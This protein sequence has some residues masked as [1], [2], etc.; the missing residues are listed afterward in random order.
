M[1][2]SSTDISVSPIQ[3]LDFASFLQSPE[4]IEAI[5]K[6]YTP[7]PT[8]VVLTNA[9][10]RTL[11]QNA[12]RLQTPAYVIPDHLFASIK[13]QELWKDSIIQSHARGMPPIKG[14]IPM[15]A[16]QSWITPA[17]VVSSTSTALDW[18][19]TAMQDWFTTYPASQRSTHI[20]ENY[21]QSIRT[22][23]ASQTPP[24]FL[25]TML[26]EPMLFQEW[27][28]AIRKYY[29]R[30][31]LQPLEVILGDHVLVLFSLISVIKYPSLDIPLPSFDLQWGCILMDQNIKMTNDIPKL[32]TKFESLT[33]PTS[34]YINMKHF[35]LFTTSS[36]QLAIKWDIFLKDVPTKIWRAAI[37]KCLCTKRA[38]DWID[39]EM[40]SKSFPSV[41]A[42]I[43][44]LI[45]NRE[46]F[47]AME[48]DPAPPRPAHSLSLP[49]Q[50]GKKA[51]VAQVKSP[52]LYSDPSMEEGGCFNPGCPL[53]N[54]RVRQCNNPCKLPDCPNPSK[55]HMAR[56]C[57]LL[58][59]ES[60]GAYFAK[61]T[62]RTA[63]CSKC[64]PPKITFSPSVLRNLQPLGPLRPPSR[65]NVL[66]ASFFPLTDSSII[67]V[68]AAPIIRFDTG[69]N[70][71]VSP[72][73]LNSS[74]VTPMCD[75]LLTAQ[76]SSVDII[77]SSP[78]GSSV[79]YIAPSLTDALISQEFIEK[80][81]CISVLVDNKLLLFDINNVNNNTLLTTIHSSLPL[82]TI[83]AINGEYLLSP[84]ILNSLVC[85]PS[86]SSET[87]LYAAKQVRKCNVV[88]AVASH[89]ANIA[90]YYTVTF[91]S[92]RDVVLYWHFA[93]GHA[94]EEKMVNIVEHQLV[95]NLPIQLTVPVIRKYFK[96]L[97]RCKPCAEA[98]LQRLSP[99][100]SS[101]SPRP[102]I[103]AVVSVL[104]L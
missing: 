10:N 55:V 25:S 39:I 18:A 84:A 36:L 29:F 61:M 56:S 35:D 15:S 102:A 75:T 12:L 91:N 42:F 28:D 82:A 68:S 13:E 63:I 30:G 46:A 37:I 80:Q 45:S 58:Y 90:R 6:A 38:R 73:S 88:R 60:A 20:T 9:H 7:P 83:D 92:L 81:G 22:D 100:P 85:T 34:R 69:A 40:P 1:S 77:G 86:I 95:R 99:L 87:A 17:P 104:A 62:V 51:N 5:R 101:T 24:P 8:A 64:I 57:N 14:R 44:R 94:N 76:G 21:S 48:P 70:I 43:Q 67:P 52:Q 65:N 49:K 96:E 16:L 3:P 41:L 2:V 33:M 98:S 97:P 79:L 93:L 74:I 31:H 50:E 11:I 66:S 89:R 23:L 27:L 71:N 72:V 4:G 78:L 47:A 26:T 54:H 103:G 59:G 19:T 53:N 32:I